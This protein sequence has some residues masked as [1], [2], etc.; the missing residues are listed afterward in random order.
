MP[1]PR[2]TMPRPVEHVGAA[3]TYRVIVTASRTW[4]LR[5]AIWGSL[6]R[7]AIEHGFEGLTIVHG[8]AEGGDKHAQAWAR[9]HA[10]HGVIDE[11]HPAT[12]R[13]G[14][15]Y[16]PA[17]GFQRNTYMVDLGAQACLVFARQCRDAKCKRTD[18]HYTHG[19]TDCATKAAEAG[20]PVH[21]RRSP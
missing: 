2:L 7:I 16:N 15:V 6:A 8:E 19:T 5:S 10:H 20:I 3:S 11:P 12:W 1:E 18:L 9:A 17:A 13:V 4:M 21:W 14:H